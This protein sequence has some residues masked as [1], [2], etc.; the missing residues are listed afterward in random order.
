MAM[1]AQLCDVERA[2]GKPIP[3][4]VAHAVAELLDE[5]EVRLAA[6]V[7]ELAERVTAELTTAD[8]LGTA[9]VGMVA[10]VLKGELWP[11]LL[12]G[13]EDMNA[14]CCRL[15][16]TRREKYLAGVSAAGSSMSLA[17]ADF[18]LPYVLRRPPLRRRDYYPW[19]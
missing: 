9:I 16:V 2:I 15:S 17:D 18:T 1:Y 10:E 8:R 4:D 14:M 7:G 3:V 11:M 13:F 19:R 5:A 6:V 12:G